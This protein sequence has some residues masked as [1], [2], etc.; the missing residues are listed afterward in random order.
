MLAS[1]WGFYSFLST[2]YRSNIICETSYICTEIHTFVLYGEKLYLTL[3]VL[4]R[5]V[6]LCYH[7]QR[8][9]MSLSAVNTKIQAIQ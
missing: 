3:N 5:A 2:V 6:V 1:I 8:T 4:T 7:H 9:E